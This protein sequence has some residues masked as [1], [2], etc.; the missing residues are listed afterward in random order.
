[1]DIAKVFNEKDKLARFLGI[2][3]IKAENG[4]AEAKVT[5]KE[6]HKNGLEIAHGGIIYTLAD[7]AFAAASNS[8]G[9]RAVAIEASISYIRSVK[10]GILTAV[11]EE[12][13]RTK[14]LGRYVVKVYDEE[15]RLCAL[16]KGT[17]YILD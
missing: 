2:K 6:E 13:G 12:V 15:K 11:A 7:L 3:V 9:K 10:D 17:S 5:L 16:F 4:C 8:Y 1:M 14:R